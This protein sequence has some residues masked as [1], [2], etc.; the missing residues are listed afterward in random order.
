MNRNESKSKNHIW[1]IPAFIIMITLALISGIL[2]LIRLPML[3]LINY[4]IDLNRVIQ[5]IFS[6]LLA[7]VVG[8]FIGWEREIKNRPAGLRTYSIVCVGSAL[9]MIISFEISNRYGIGNFDPTRLG[10]Q[11]ISGIGFLGAGTIIR[12]KFSVKG[13]TTAASLWVAACIGLAIGARI[14]FI[15]ILASAVVYY[16]MYGLR[17]MEEL[18]NE[19]ESYEIILRIHEKYEQLHEIHKMLN[20]YEVEIKDFNI[21]Y[22]NKGLLDDEHDDMIIIMNVFIEDGDINN[23]ISGF[24]HIKGIVSVQ[25]SET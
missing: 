8:S 5:N 17:T 20:K 6:V 1:S 13:L 16:I 10:A 12:D 4:E 3:N 2:G 18:N 22:G 11:V 15:S 23:L 14:Y 7:S 25:Y 19:R 9:V 24:N 21:N